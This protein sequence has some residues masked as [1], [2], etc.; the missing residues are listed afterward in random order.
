VPRTP[1]DVDS[2][3]VADTAEA[4]SRSLVAWGLVAVWSLAVCIAHFGGLAYRTYWQI[5]WWDVLTHTAAGLGVAAILYLLRPDLYRSP[6]ALFV[7]LPLTVLAIGAGFE[8]YERVFRTFWH[9]WSVAYYVEDTVIDLVMDTAGA[10]AL[11]VL[12]VL[13][14]AVRRVTD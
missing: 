2:G 11:S 5:A 9:S 7:A 8:V 10:L 13:V 14:R 3:I 12:V 1:V 6:V 4:A